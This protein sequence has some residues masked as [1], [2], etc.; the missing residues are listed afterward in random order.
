[1][2]RRPTNAPTQH[3]LIDFTQPVPT[4]G[5]HLI[6]V[7]LNTHSKRWGFFEVPPAVVVAQDAA[8]DKFAPDNMAYPFNTVAEATVGAVNHAAGEAVAI[9]GGVTV[10]GIPANARITCSPGY[11][12]C[13]NGGLYDLDRAELRAAYEQ[14]HRKSGDHARQ[15]AIHY[16]IPIGQQVHAFFELWGKQTRRSRPKL[17]DYLDEMMPGTDKRTRQRHLKTFAIVSSDDWPDMVALAE[18]EITGMA[19]ILRLA[20]RSTKQR[21]RKTKTPLKHRYLALRD[22]VLSGKYAEARRLIEQYDDEDY[23]PWS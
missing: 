8:D 5:E 9:H 1:M 13:I 10:R 2:G 15:G 16:D 18:E 14:T 6:R 22:A 11:R 12:A 7:V 17:H 21:P 20:K 19:S 3:P 4:V 23:T